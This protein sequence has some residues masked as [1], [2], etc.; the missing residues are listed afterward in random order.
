[1]ARRKVSEWMTNTNGDFFQF[2]KVIALQ[3]LALIRELNGLF[4]AV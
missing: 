1:M 4:T 3:N 2:I